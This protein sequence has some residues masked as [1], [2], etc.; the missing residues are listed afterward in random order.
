MPTL[1][2]EVQPG[3]IIS[4]EL[5]TEILSRLSQLSDAVLTGTQSVPNLIGLSLT[6]ARTLIQQPSLQLALGFVVDATGAVI[7]PNAAAN[8][9]LIVLNQSPVASHLAPVNS[10]VDLI[11]SQSAGASPNPNP[12]PQPTITIT[13]TIEGDSATEFAVGESMV[14][15]GNNFSAISSQNI[16]TFNGVSAIVSSDPADPTR[17]LIIE[18]PSSVPGA[19]VNPGDDTLENVVVILR[20]AI[21]NL[22]ATTQIDIAAPIPN[23]PTITSLSDSLLFEGQN[24]TIIG[25]NFTEASVVTIRGEVASIA[26]LNAPTSLEVTVPEFDDIPANAVVSA[27]VV[28]TNPDAGSAVFPGQF[29]IMGAPN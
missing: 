19:P 29:N 17:R 24:L 12:G 27:Q 9:N 1:P 2:S 14:L 16:V 26:E 6:D 20:H 11:V 21:S 23:S 15:V 8:A 13:E 5:M 22:S 4:S 7:N 25:T 10:S 18:V 3:D 28:V